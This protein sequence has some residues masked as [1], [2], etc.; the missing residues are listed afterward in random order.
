MLLAII[1]GCLTVVVKSSEFY[2]QKAL[3]MI[4]LIVPKPKSTYES[5]HSSRLIVLDNSRPVV[6]QQPR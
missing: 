6:S 1:I 4:G 5:C 3:E 2:E